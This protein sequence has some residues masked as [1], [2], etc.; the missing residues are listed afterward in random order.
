MK[1]ILYSIAILFATLNFGCHSDGGHLS[2]KTKDTGTLFKFEANYA[3]SKTGKL[4]KYLDS[5]LN[6]ELPLDQDIDLFVNLNGGD[7]FNLKAKKGWLEINFD[8]R[9]S[10]LAGYV[11]VKKLTD[12][13]KQKL[14]E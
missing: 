4:E 3:G 6:N 10:S 12:G 1:N 13:I 9:N 7:K 14:S 11:K 2:I 5:A 8:K